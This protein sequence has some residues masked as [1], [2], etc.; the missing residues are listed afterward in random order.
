MRGALKTVPTALFTTAPGMSA[1]GASSWTNPW[2]GETHIYHSAAQP[3]SIM[4]NTAKQAYFFEVHPDQN[5]YF[6]AKAPY[7]RD[8]AEISRDAFSRPHA[9]DLWTAGHL[10][11]PHHSTLGASGGQQP[12]IHQW[13]DKG[14]AGD[15]G[16]M[17]PPVALIYTGSALRLQYVWSSQDP[18]A[19]TNTPLSQTLQNVITGKWYTIV[20]R[21]KA[22]PTHT[23]GEIQVWIDGV[24]KW[25]YSGNLSTPNVLGLYEKFG[26]YR[27][28][29]TA[30]FAVCWAGMEN[31]SGVSLLSRINETK[32]DWI[33]STR[34][35]R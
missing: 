3:Y 12:I 25:T 4:Y 35:S 30:N 8:R 7:T 10:Y 14:D 18:Y 26:I 27:F 28:S 15:A 17:P 32:P 6:D 21:V 20:M 22:G 16:G 29:D 1:V 23:G 33:P 31:T 9:T 34:R 5:A 2:N 11:I 19:G 13:H 24:L